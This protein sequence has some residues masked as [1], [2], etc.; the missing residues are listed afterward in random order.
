MAIVLVVEMC[1]TVKKCLWLAQLI[2]YRYHR[3]W[4]HFIVNKSNMSHIIVL[5]Y[6]N[7]EDNP[8]KKNPHTHQ[9]A[10]SS[11]VMFLQNS[12]PNK[13]TGRG[14]TIS[15]DFSIVLFAPTDCTAVGTY[16]ML[17]SHCR[18]VYYKHYDWQTVKL[19]YKYKLILR[20]EASR[21]VLMRFFDV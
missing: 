13:K 11:V 2:F 5:S 3:I 4:W 19:F 16:F 17:N 7:S 9:A 14:S 18:S 1:L 10:L 8:W 21:Y 20:G 6:R 12:Y 15:Y